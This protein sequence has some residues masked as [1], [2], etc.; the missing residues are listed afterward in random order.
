VS[1]AE[2][3]STTATTTAT[4]TGIVVPAVRAAFDTTHSVVPV[5]EVAHYK[6]AVKANKPKLPDQV[7]VGAMSAV[8]VVCLWLLVAG[9]FLGYDLQRNAQASQMNEIFVGMFAGIFATARLRGAGRQT[10][11]LAMLFGVWLAVVPYIANY[12]SDK[13]P[14][15]LDVSAGCF[16]AAMSLIG[17]TMRRGA[18]S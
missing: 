13:V 4:T 15:I 12:S 18:P 1:H 6:A 5:L 10:A 14:Q 2:G 9:W 3:P 7:R 17:A 8:L 11:V 16:I